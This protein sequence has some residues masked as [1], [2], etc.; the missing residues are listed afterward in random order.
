MNSANPIIFK[1]RN[2]IIYAYSKDRTAIHTLITEG[3]RGSRRQYRPW[4]SCY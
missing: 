1:R 4:N 3:M 2:N